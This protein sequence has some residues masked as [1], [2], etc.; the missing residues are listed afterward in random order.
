MPGPPK[1]GH[2]GTKIHEGHEALLVR[3]VVSSC[4]RDFVLQGLGISR[5]ADVNTASSSRS[6]FYEPPRSLYTNTAGVMR[7]AIGS[8]CRNAYRGSVSDVAPMMST[9]KLRGVIG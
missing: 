2:E 4:L 3:H 7:S 9:P 5:Y 8:E 6:L 1:G